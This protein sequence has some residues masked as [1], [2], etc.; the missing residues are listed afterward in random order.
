MSLAVFVSYSRQE[1]PF[2]D[3]LLDELEDRGF[4]VW[5]DY[6]SLTP[7]KPWLEEIYRGIEEADVVLLVVSKAVMVS[8]FASA[9]M[10][11]AFELK[12][13]IV[14][15]IFE[16]VELPPWLQKYEWIDFRSSF[17]KGLSELVGQLQS[18]KVNPL[19]PPQKGFA[20]PPVVW[21]SFIVS[22]GVCL[23]S[24]LAF[25]TLYI[26]YFVLPLPY[27]I[28]KRNFNY[29][30]V[31]LALV[32]LPFA[33]IVSLSLDPGKP[34]SLGP[35][36]IFWM[37][38]FL[39]SLILVPLLFLLL[40]S[41]QMRLW[42]KP[43]ASRPSFANRYHPKVIQPRPITFA[44]EAAPEDI[45]YNYDLT[46]GMEKYG[47][48]FVPEAEAEVVFV[49]ISRYHKAT[50]LNPEARIVYPVL[51]QSTEG[52]DPK[53]E[54]VQW[55]DFR[56]GFRNVDALAQLIPEPTKIF[57]ALGIAPLGNQTVLPPIIRALE[58]YLIVLGIFTFGGWATSMVQ[59]SRVVS[60][61]DGL[62]SVFW[63]GIILGSIFLA[64]HSIIH[65]KGRMA[66]PLYL[67]PVLTL[68]LG[69]SVVY[70]TGQT[71]QLASSASG[72][73]DDL[74]GNVM[75]ASLFVYV[76]GLVLITP[77][78]LWYW[79][80]FRRWCPQMSKRKPRTASQP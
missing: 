64:A 14:L 9:E 53:M 7:A 77:L 39:L 18:P 48:R 58:I 71:I 57:K 12:K 5:M 51:L 16:A 3:S 78:A 15:I 20:A 30:Y 68:V 59:L 2:A 54:R 37:L 44:V 10:E 26:P 19:G 45:R 11:T 4:K 46:K 63:L 79:K 75:L 34:T 28:L 49:L 60:W 52:I 25:W 80:D 8:K 43:I 72:M 42:G 24:L 21:F 6:Q 32:L 31:Q 38:S 29:F 33:L 55:I 47:H 70:L 66:T 35:F 69:W 62:G 65:R 41:K 50:T 22:L 76:T 56:R 13:R 17:T 27:R 67:I 40:R 36:E 1:A 61:R 73:E 23:I 74:R